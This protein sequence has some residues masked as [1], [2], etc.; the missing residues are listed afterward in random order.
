MKGR[1]KSERDIGAI[2]HGVEYEWCPMPKCQRITFVN[3]NETGCHA[4]IG[5]EKN[6]TRKDEGQKNSDNLRFLVLPKKGAE[7]SSIIYK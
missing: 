6:N 5:C 7:H 3:K 2:R 1:G 4:Q